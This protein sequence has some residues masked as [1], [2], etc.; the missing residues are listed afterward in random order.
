MN[1]A[2]RRGYSSPLRVEQ[3]AATRQR[4]LDAAIALLQETG[5]GEV[6]IPDVAERAGVSVSTA[7]RAFTTRDALLAGVLEELKVRFE[8]VAGPRPSTMDEL[9]DSV[10]RA[11][12]AVL[13]VEDLYRALFAIPEGRVL[14]RS[15]ASQ[16]SGAIDKALHSELAGL[17]PGLTPAQARRF[18]AVLH[19]V[20]SSHAVLF[21]KDYEG[22]DATDTS[23]T[24]G[25]VM[26]VLVDA[27]RDPAR[28]S[29]L[30]PT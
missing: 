7:Y 14:H 3:A 6:A 1:G 4:I 5:S 21:L 27:V 26:R 13:E 10:G 19:L 11:V 25:W 22:L 29:E 30:E 23:T 28:R 18:V 16:R 24:M 15:T 20:S 9:V 12:P 17:D 8:T 2:G